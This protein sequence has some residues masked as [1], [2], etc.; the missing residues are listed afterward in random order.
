[1]CT[2]CW[3][4]IRR[5]TSRSRRWAARSGAPSADRRSRWRSSTGSPR[6]GTGAALTARSA[7]LLGPGSGG[8]RT[9][10]PQEPLFERGQQDTRRLLAPE[11]RTGTAPNGGDWVCGGEPSK[12]SSPKSRAACAGR[13]SRHPSLE[14]ERR[15][16]TGYRASASFAAAITRRGGMR[17][18]GIRSTP[19]R[20]LGG[21]AGATVFSMDRELQSPKLRANSHPKVGYVCEGNGGTDG[22]RTRDLVLDRDAC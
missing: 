2:H 1:M 3:L 12:R 13:Q 5:F 17:R 22:I 9:P 7:R 20:G 11:Q 18:T 8:L 10:R 6:E 15:T 14:Q 19:T 21:N 16:A 4:C